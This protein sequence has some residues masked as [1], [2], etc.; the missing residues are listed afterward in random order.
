[1]ASLVTG[2]AGF[3]GAELAHMLVA[4]GEDV[5]LFVRTIRKE[6]IGDIQ[7]RVKVVQG[8]LGNWSHVLGAVKDYKV[9]RI[10]HTGAMLSMESDANPWGSFQTNV[11]GIYNVLEA[12]R[13]LDVERVMFTSTL[14]AFGAGVGPE[15]TDTSLQ[16]PHEMYG[17]SKLFGEGLGRFYRR[18]FG[19]DFRSIRY[20]TVV[21]PGVPASP[22]HWDAPMIE[23]AIRGQPYECPVSGDASAPMIYYKDASRAAVMVLQAPKEKIQMVNYN[24]AGVA[25]MVSARD[26]EVTIKKYIPGAA[27]TYTKN[28]PP[29]PFHSYI[30]VWDDAYARQEWGWKPQVTTIDE[31]VTAFIDEMRTH[32]RHYGLT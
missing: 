24:V 30:K 28:P 5:V 18:R 14:G 2:G 31:L 11:V 13:L 4:S 17:V 25:A 7:D 8:D 29:L 20:P 26:L 23:C 10:Y 27:I 3:I 22:A 32:P 21:G 15:L 1:M 19:L 16:R 6:R 12:A 9:T